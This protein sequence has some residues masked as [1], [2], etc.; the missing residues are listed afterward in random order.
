MI[1]LVLFLFAGLGDPSGEFLMPDGSKAEMSKAGCINGELEMVM[2]VSEFVL[3]LDLLGS[4]QVAVG[5]VCSGLGSPI[6]IR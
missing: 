3:A 4:S 2:V 1:L 5:Q 6:P